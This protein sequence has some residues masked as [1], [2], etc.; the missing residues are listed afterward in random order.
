MHPLLVHFPIALLSIYALMEFVP[1]RF[2]SKFS[3]WQG[4][5]IFL[6]ALGVFSAVPTM[7]AGDIDSQLPERM[8]VHN[9]V[10]KHEMFALLTVNLFMVLLGAYVVRLLEGTRSLAK[11]LSFLGP[12]AKIWK[13]IHWISKFILRTPARL[14]VVIV[15]LVFLAI[16]G[17][18]GAS[19]VYGPNVDPVVNFIYNLIM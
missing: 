10:E 19:I 18:L 4:T 9:L 7:I 14:M 5:K 8:K 3:W 6:L 15:A 11:W 16:A 1:Q 17:G 2:V 12:L 13:L